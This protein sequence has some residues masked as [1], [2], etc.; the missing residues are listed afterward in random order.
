MEIV[1]LPI[2]KRFIHVIIPYGPYDINLYGPYYT[3]SYLLPTD[4]W[5]LIR[6][7]ERIRT[8]ASNLIDPETELQFRT[9][10]D[11]S[12]KGAAFIAATSLRKTDSIW[13][14]LRDFVVRPNICYIFK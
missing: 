12:A 13:F 8:E 1:P 5:M 3:V 6:E 10:F 7:I 14:M 2:R 11:G 4:F 9:S